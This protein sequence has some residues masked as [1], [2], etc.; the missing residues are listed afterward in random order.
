VLV[1]AHYANR[2][3]EHAAE[4]LGR[5]PLREVEPEGVAEEIGQ[6]AGCLAILERDIPRARA[7]VEE[8]GRMGRVP[9]RAEVYL[10]M[11]TGIIHALDGDLDGAAR[12]YERAL[13]V[14]AAGAPWEE[15]MLL[16]RLALVELARGRT[17][18]ALECAE[19]MERAAPKLGASGERLVPQALRA[20]ARRLAGDPVSDA[21]LLEVLGLL[22][23]DSRARFAELVC[24]LAEGEL[25]RGK[26]EPCRAL[27]E[28]AGAAAERVARPSL[29]VSSHALLARAERLRGRDD[30]ARTH[31]ALAR[32]A[33]TPSVPMARAVRALEEETALLEGAGGAVAGPA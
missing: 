25:E 21:E 5:E 14:L 3:A 31:L 20:V 17:G 9:P 26:V 6:V 23:P 30:L 15:S 11:A 12:S 10:A 27:L 8:S 1:H 2:D 19:R 33:L 32:R 22:E 4:L 28:R 7:I 29:V 16:A 24:A 18:R 13:A